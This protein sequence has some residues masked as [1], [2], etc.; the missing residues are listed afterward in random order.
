MKTIL[1]GL[2]SL[3]FIQ[4]AFATSSQELKSQLAT[5]SFDEDFMPY[6]ED[7]GFNRENFHH[8]PAIYIQ[9]IHHDV[10]QTKMMYQNL[11]HKLDVRETKRAEVVEKKTR[12]YFDLLDEYQSTIENLNIVNGPFFDETF[13]MAEKLA[14]NDSGKFKSFIKH[15]PKALALVPTTFLGNAV[16]LPKAGLA[17]ILL[18][19][20]IIKARKALNATLKNK[21]SKL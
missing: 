1:F 21:I 7:F 16:M 9:I 19:K 6:Y 8:D 14:S 10:S 17:N 20:D 15:L 2:L 11:I 3:L 18:K 12:Q 4:T 5:L 13:A